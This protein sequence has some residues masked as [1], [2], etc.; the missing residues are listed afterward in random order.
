MTQPITRI[1][2]IETSCDET[3]AAVVENGTTIL[4][5]VI[6]SQ[7]DLHAQYGGVF[8][9]LASRKHIEVIYPV[10]Q[11]AMAEAHLGF[12]DLDAIAVTQGPGL[13]GSLLVGVN[14]AKGIALARRKPIIGVNHIEGHIYSLWLTDVPIQF[15]IL[16]L[17]V[18]GGHTE[19]YLMR[20]HGQYE[21]LG[22]TLDDAAGEAFDKVGRLLGLPFPGGPAIDKA[23]AEGNPL[24]FSFPRAVMGDGYNFS[25]S[26]LKTAVLREV[27]KFSPDRLP[28]NDLAASFQAAVID[29]LVTKTNAAA[30]A[31]K[32]AAVH[33]T[34]G[35]SANRGLRQAM[36]E[37][38]SVPVYY[39]PLLLC[40]DN[41][42][43]IAAV[44]HQHYR[45]QRFSPLNFDVIPSLQLQ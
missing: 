1:L 11:Q 36:R 26:G 43:M 35:V 19:L 30:Q 40:T 5:N 2:G 23:A 7:T 41:A 33:L 25:F 20:D 9:E 16:S 27:Q 4:S 15:P 13:V 18:S 24:A 3:A 42:A 44:G 34:G 22:G 31:H 12:D 17:V 32:V 29:V 39:P 6:A 10:I 14:A 37:R 21:H 8:P 28:L 45:Q 38:L